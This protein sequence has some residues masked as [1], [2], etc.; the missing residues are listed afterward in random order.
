ME[1]GQIDIPGSGLDGKDLLEG[2]LKA[3]SPLSIRY[4]A[5]IKI[6][7]AQHGG[8]EDIRKKLG[9][10]RRRMCQLLMVDPSAWT[11]WT[12]DENRVP[13]HVYRALEWFIALNE[14]AYTQ[15]ELAAIF[16]QRYKLSSA[17]TPKAEDSHMIQAMEAR[18]LEMQAKIEEQRKLTGGLVAAGLAFVACMLTY[19]FLR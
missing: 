4:A 1:L 6:F 7:K 2:R 13:P 9:F 18:I 17:L 11:R 14:R 12:K 5:E 10:S 16:T 8:L 15:P 3:K 19:L